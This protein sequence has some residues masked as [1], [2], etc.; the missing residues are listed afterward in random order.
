M[1]HY[2]YAPKQHDGRKR[3]KLWLRFIAGIYISYLN[4]RILW[5]LGQYIHTNKTFSTLKM[6]TMNLINYWKSCF[7]SISSSL[8]S[9]NHLTTVRQIILTTLDEQKASVLYFL[10][11]LFCEIWSLHSER[12]HSLM[13]RGQRQNLIAKFALQ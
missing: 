12:K 4:Q 11:S 5:F 6:S 10:L 2:W 1:Q 9:R 8:H 13:L 7:Q 3:K